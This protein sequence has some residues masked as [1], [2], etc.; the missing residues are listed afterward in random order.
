MNNDTEVEVELQKGTDQSSAAIHEQAP[1]V[2]TT[3]MQALSASQPAEDIL[4]VNKEAT[5]SNDVNLAERSDSEAETVVLDGQQDAPSERTVQAIKNE[6]TSDGDGHQVGRPNGYHPQFETGKESDNGSDRSSLKRKRT[7]QEH[8]GDNVPSSILTSVVSSPRARDHSP[9]DNSPGSERTHPTPTMDE[10]IEQKSAESQKRKVAPNVDDH[11]R[12]K[13]G[14]SD[15][16]SVPVHRKERREPRLS[17]H[18]ELPRRR[19]DSPPSQHQKRAQSAYLADISEKNNRRKAPPPMLVENRNKASV[20]TRGESDDSTSI[21]SHPH[22]Q[23]VASVDHNIMSPAKVSHKTRRDR[24]GRTHLARAC[25]SGLAEAQ[26][27]LEERPEDI[28]EPDNAGNTPLQIAS[29]EGL[30][31][32]VKLLLDA[33]CDTT[34]KNIDSDT[35]LIDAVEN[36]HLDVVRLLLDARLNP[37]QCNSRGEEPLDLVNPEDDQCEEIRAALMEAKERHILRRPSGDLSV[38][39]RDND[40]SSMGASAPSPIDGPVGKSP[41]PPGLGPRRRTAR[42]QP[43]EDKLLWVNPTPEK[44]REA[45]EKGDMNMVGHILG[46]NHQVGTDAV[47]AATR[48][49]HDEILGILLAVGTT[50]PDPDPIESNDSKPGRNTPMLAA[51]GRGHLPVIKLLVNQREFNP[52]RRI[53]DGLTYH[54][55]AEKRRGSSWEEEF[56]V[57]KEA[58]DDYKKHGN[59][60]STHNSPRKVRSR[61]AEAGRPSSTSPSSLNKTSPSS[62]SVKIAQ[63]PEIKREDSQRAPRKHLSHPDDHKDSAVVS[64]RESDLNGLLEPK[65]KA[66]RS[67]SEALQTSSKHSDAAKPR[68]KLVSRNEIKSDQDAKRRA[69]LAQGISSQEP[70]TAKTDDPPKPVHKTQERKTSESS[71]SVPKVRRGTSKEH[72]SNIEPGRK[73]PRLSTSPSLP[74]A[75]NERPQ[76]ALLNK[77]K[78]RLDSEGNAIMPYP[79]VD[80]LAVRTGQARVANMIASPE[81]VTS[82]NEPPRAPVAN[83]GVSSASP[84]TRSPT[85]PSVQSELHPPM[86][87]IEEQLLEPSPRPKTLEDDG[88]EAPIPIHHNEAEGEPPDDM[89]EEARRAAEMER[90]QAARDEEARLARI[91]EEDKQA[92]LERQRQ[93][94]AAE[95]AE[96]A[97]RERQGKIEKQEEEARLA[98]KRREEDQAKRRAEQERL[99]REEQERRRAEHEERERL[100]RIRQQEEERQARLEA[101]P[102][103]LRRAAQL[104]PDNARRPVELKKWLPFR[105]VT[106][107][108]IDPDCRDDVANEKWIANVQVA[109]VLAITDLDLSQCKSHPHAQYAYP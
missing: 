99:K 66:I 60:R 30:A 54:E 29:L 36:G 106:T 70:P 37:Y 76:D 3:A 91:A 46:M 81:H 89:H 2:V 83:M 11:D 26:R 32:V 33:G 71:I 109:P 98:K 64:D 84:T 14:K 9:P 57:L 67:V 47:I 96:A 12:K 48:G 101:L 87:G 27:L 94:E 69:S 25:A 1:P 56:A 4:K 55:L 107:R 17:T 38:H 82:P 52:T 72:S 39:D 51:I 74:D 102:N 73:R 62:T 77:K 44:L 18:H 19:S 108:Q 34:C 85:E 63:G 58:Y 88:K 13:R 5:G 10:G 79:P 49:G 59:T 15:P 97:E 41:P 8:D 40:M 53:F 104:S 21:H 95:G 93:A 100:R 28:N 22:L 24:N 45:C 105:S 35:P 6:D 78:R 80:P 43:T 16:N 92:R 7:T 68:R 75:R 23:K 103:G 50:E 90:A 31:D 65:P 20:E 42:S 61:R 86:A